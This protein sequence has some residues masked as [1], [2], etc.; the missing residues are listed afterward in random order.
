[1]S[2]RF[3]G[4]TQ[5]S[6]C[7]GKG[8]IG[9]RCLTQDGNRRFPPTELKE[10][11]S[12]I[13]KDRRSAW[14]ECLALFEKD[15]GWLEPAVFKMLDALEEQGTRLCNLLVG[16]V[17]VD[18]HVSVAGAAYQLPISS[19]IPASALFLSAAETARTKASSRWFQDNSTAPSVR[20]LGYHGLGTI[21]PIRFATQRPLEQLF[22]LAGIAGPWPSAMEIPLLRRRAR[23]M[24]APPT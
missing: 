3:I 7:L 8:R 4:K 15:A 9:S 13:A 10:G 23:A 16:R 1:M 19:S 21:A 22:M 24:A 11:D 17:C 5:A 20:G 14:S 12:Q 2:L 6:P 18:S